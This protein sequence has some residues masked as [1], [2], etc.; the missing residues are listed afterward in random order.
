MRICAI[1]SFDNEDKGLCGNVRHGERMV[2]SVKTE[3]A[4]EI[5]IIDCF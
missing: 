1:K 4:N 3:F 2:S 5:I